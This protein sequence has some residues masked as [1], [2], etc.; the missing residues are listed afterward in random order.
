[1]PK[2]DTDGNETAGLPSVQHQAP[3]GTYTGWNVTAGGFFK[4]QPC[5]GGLTGGYIPFAKTTCGAARFR[6]SAA[7]ARGALRD[8]AGV[9]PAAAQ[10][11]A[12]EVER[13]LLLPADAR[14][15]IEQAEGIDAAACRPCYARMPL[16]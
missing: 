15:L 3:L 9:M 14:S 1:M 8:P 10:G 2:L 16:P 4:G 13:R 12:R 11:A 5:G 6:R 7:V